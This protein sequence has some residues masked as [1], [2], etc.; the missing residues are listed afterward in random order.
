VIIFVKPRTT[1][2]SYVDFWTLVELSG[3]PTCDPDQ[4]DWQSDNVYICSPLNGEHNDGWTER[5]TQPRQCHLIH[6][7]LERDPSKPPDSR[8]DEEW[9]SDRWY[10]EQ[11]NVVGL[12]PRLAAFVSAGIKLAR[13]LRTPCR[14][15]TLGIHP[16]LSRWS[17]VDE[18]LRPRVVMP[19]DGLSYDAI[20]L[21]YMSHRRQAIIPKLVEQM[22][23]KLHPQDGN[24]WG[25]ERHQA[26]L[27]SRAMLA[28]HQDEHP[29]IEPLRYALAAAYGL[30]IWGEDGTDHFPWQ[31]WE[32]LPL[33]QLVH[34]KP[35]PLSKY[36]FK[37]HVDAAVETFLED[38]G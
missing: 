20:H 4:V 38:Q 8:F 16:G 21:S 23:W 3:Y 9:R 12:S 32:N 15:V 13:E 26:L 14:Y 7:N 27:Q 19:H 22:G 18:N 28:I 2:P 24:L 37:C 35:P 10:A 31:R 11:D 34:L 36:L 1:Y 25:E 17:Q 29:I 33:L 6:W 5:A 30:P